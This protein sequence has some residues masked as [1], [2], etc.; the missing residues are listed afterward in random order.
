MGLIKARRKFDAFVVDCTSRV[1]G[2][3]AWDSIDDDSRMFEK[4]VRLA[5][6]GD[7]TTVWVDGR[8]VVDH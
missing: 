6:P 5:G 3:D 7:I 8:I 1:S 4:I 2:L